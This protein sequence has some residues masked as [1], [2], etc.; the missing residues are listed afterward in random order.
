MKFRV[1][2]TKTNKDITDK[3]KWFIDKDGKLLGCPKDIGIPIYVA[4][5]C[6]YYKLEITVLKNNL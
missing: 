5:D 6:Y 1:Y 2:E 4:D 3:N